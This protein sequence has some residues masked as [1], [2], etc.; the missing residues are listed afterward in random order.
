MIDTFPT[1]MLVTPQ[2]LSWCHSPMSHK[3]ALLLSRTAQKC[4]RFTLF[5]RL[6]NSRGKRDHTSVS[7]LS[8]PS[9]RPFWGMISMISQR[10]PC[11][12]KPSLPTMIIYTLT[13]ALGVFL[14]FGLYFLFFQLEIAWIP[15]QIYYLP[16]TSLLLGQLL[17]GIQSKR[18]SMTLNSIYTLWLLLCFSFE[19]CL[20]YLTISVF[21]EH[22]F[23]SFHWHH[24]PL[25]FLL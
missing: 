17:R 23:L 24:I 16:S 12:M 4:K 25:I 9:V 18:I 15:I 1:Q 2:C 21:G 10:P 11:W 8:S 14:L 19:L 22:Y 3:V 5:M 13:H 6:L 20:I 7:R